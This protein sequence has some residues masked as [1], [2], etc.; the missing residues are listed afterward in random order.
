MLSE[1]SHWQAVASAAAT[2]AGGVPINAVLGAHVIEV[3]SAVRTQFGTPIYG[4]SGELSRAW[5]RAAEVL[6]GVYA[7]I[8]AVMLIEAWLAAWGRAA[9]RCRGGAP[10]AKGAGVTILFNDNK[11]LRL[12]LRYDAGAPSPGI[13]RA[14]LSDAAGFGRTD[15]ASTGWR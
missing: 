9:V 3:C 1:A 11:D 13:A 5:A 7:R 8:F 14:C 15:A 2:A 6:G 12:G 4:M 10:Q